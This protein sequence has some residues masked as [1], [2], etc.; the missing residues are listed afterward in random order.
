MIRILFLSANPNKTKRLAV[1]KE[2]KH[3]RDSINSSRY[4]TQCKLDQMP[5][6]SVD[7]LDR[8]IIEFEPQIVHFSGHGTQEG[9][10]IFRSSS[11][12]REWSQVRDIADLFR[13]LIE[14]MSVPED[15]KIRCVVLSSCYSQRQAM[16]IAKY[17]DC[18]IGMSNAISD[19]AAIIFAES[20][21]LGLAS[22]K[23]IQTAFELGRSKVARLGLAGQDIPEMESREG[24]DPSNIF[25]VGDKRV[26]KG[27]SKSPAFNKICVM[28][29]PASLLYAPPLDGSNYAYRLS[30]ERNELKRKLWKLEVTDNLIKLYESYP[31]SV[32][33]LFDI[34]DNK[35]HILHFSID[36]KEKSLLG[37]TCDISRLD[38]S[39]FKKIIEVVGK[40]IVCIVLNGCYSKNL[41]E[42]FTRYVSCV[43]G[44]PDGLSFEECTALLSS[45]YKQV[46]RKNILDA[47]N[48][49]LEE[50]RLEIS[51]DKKLPE[52]LPKND[53]YLSRI[54]LGKPTDLTS[55]SLIKER[56]NMERDLP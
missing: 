27:I 7:E 41:A 48:R 42:M 35:L 53:S 39:Y 37:K 52:L 38:S 26:K 5:Q 29:L 28:L 13:I 18:V 34:F 40:D 20:F 49:A 17:V 43:I 1:D 12:K 15:K 25:L 44:V 23:S 9:I 11:G 32:G 54:T 21:Y 46:C 33:E 31:N 10:L 50:L 45:F 3:I 8:V 24:I 47:Y 14:D 19:N 55:S 2:Y 6:V 4:S 22:G 16:A 30:E 51:P 56:F 36:Q